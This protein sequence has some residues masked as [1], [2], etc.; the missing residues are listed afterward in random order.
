MA[1]GII[2]ECVSLAKVKGIHLD[3]NEVMEN[4]ILISQKS[5]GQLISTYM[6]ILNKRQTEIESLN[7]EIAKIADEVGHPELVKNTRILG[8][9]ILIKS[10]LINYKSL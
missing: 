1:E 10:N 2:E 3:S 8:Q 5:D 4:L 6:D 7:L 9:L